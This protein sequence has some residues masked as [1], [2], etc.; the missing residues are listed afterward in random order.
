MTQETVIGKF[1]YTAP[2]QEAKV[3]LLHRGCLQGDT[4]LGVY[5][6]EVHAMAAALDAQAKEQEPG[7]CH[8]VIPMPLLTSI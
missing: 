6:H 8:T 5:A 2:T 4:L 1:E 7:A 3:Y